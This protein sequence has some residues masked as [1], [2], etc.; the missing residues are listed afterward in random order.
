[1]SSIH[2]R[3]VWKHNKEQEVGVLA[4]GFLKLDFE[5]VADFIVKS[6]KLYLV[7]TRSPLA[8]NPF[9]LRCAT[10]FL[11][12]PAAISIPEYG[13]LETLGG[14]APTLAFKG[15]VSVTSTPH[16]GQ[17]RYSAIRPFMLIRCDSLI[18]NTD[19]GLRQRT[20]MEGEWV[21]SLNRVA[22]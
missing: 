4:V 22:N 19:V 13:G 5:M 8:L 1:V 12:V 9:A 20:E 16:L 3:K 17:G 14:R 15:G 7:F 18:Q 2:R 6:R 11:G 21:A 10:A